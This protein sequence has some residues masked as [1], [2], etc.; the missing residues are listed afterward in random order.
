MSKKLSLVS[1]LVPLILA[2]NQNTVPL[3][4]KTEEPQYQALY[5]NS[6]YQKREFRGVWIASVANI[7]WPSRKGL[8]SDEQKAEYIKLAEKAKETGLNAL[9]VQVRAATDAF[10]LKSPEPWSEWLMGVQGKAP[11]P[12]YDPMTFMI[13]ETH[14]RGMEFHAWLNLNRG[15]HKKASS[16]MSDH[17][18][19][20]R[21]EWFLTYDGYKLFNFGL[22]EVRKYIKDV[23]MN[24]VREYD[25][26]GIHFD[27][28]F[29]PY[30][31]TG[32]NLNDEV[33]FKKYP[34][35]LSNI[36]DWRRHNID[37]IVKEISE[38]IRAEKPW[39][40]FGISPFGVWRNKSDDPMGSET[41]GGQPS[42]D[43]LFAD[44]RKW[45]QEG[46]IDYI[47]PQIYFPFEHKLV[48]YA[49][50][51]DWWAQHRGKA[52]LYIG[53]GVYRVDEESSQSPWR[54]ANQIGRQVDY[55]R[56]SRNVNGSIF[57]SANGF[58]KNN[59]GV[60][61]SLKNRFNIIALPPVT[62]Q[63]DI[64]ADCSVSDLSIKNSGSAKTLFW[65]LN[66]AE[67]S[68]IY[69][70]EKGES[71]NLNDPSKILAI[72]KFE[73]FSDQ[74]AVA[75]KAYIYAVTGLDR[76]KRESKPDFIEL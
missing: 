44:T 41:R 47:A 3:V 31:V 64:P 8:S 60:A 17:L 50:L 48:P 13:D 18:I 29:Y 26:D 75:N 76:F 73:R 53:H 15:M 43:F 6:E 55:N 4:E 39:V 42:Y 28:Y 63:K 68:V 22:P 5:E 51:T 14:E 36:E 34:D 20:T 59:L 65:K 30:K 35:G 69:R 11:S 23:V 38:G 7:D 52:D 70:F 61:D 37:L 40:K 1:F 21:P 27:D 9:L 19:Y 74:T 56:M 49:T 2:C 32:Q 25:V 46:W 57:F 24:I 66:K 58:L 54:D 10:Y 71:L 45:A 33:T 67:F 16:V 62:G 12:V 72:G